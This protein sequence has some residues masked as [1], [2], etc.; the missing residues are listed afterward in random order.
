MKRF[1]TKA[2]NLFSVLLLAFALC[3]SLLCVAVPE[4]VTATWDGTAAASFASGS[5]TESSPYK[6]STEKQL[7]YFLQ[8][9]AAGVTYEGKY[10]QLTKSLDMTGGTWECAGTFQ[11][12]F[13]GM[14]YTITAECRFLN[15]VGEYGTVQGVNY[16]ATKTLDDDVFCSYNEGSLIG[17]VVMGDAKSDTSKTIWEES[18]GLLC[19]DNYGSVISCGGVGYVYAC[20]DDSSA[21]AGLIAKNHG[22]V[23]SCYSAVASSASAPGKYNYSHSHPLAGA[24]SGSVTNCIYNADIYT[25]TTNVGIGMTTEEMTGATILSLL[26]DNA[27]TNCRWALNDDFDGY[28]HMAPASPYKSYVSGYQ[29]KDLIVYNANYG[30]TSVTLSKNSS[31]GTIYY[32]LD[33]EETDPA[34]FTKYT[35]GSISIEGYQVLSSSVY[36]NGKFGAVTRQ[37]LFH[38]PGSGTVASPYQISTPRQLTALN[39][40]PEA[41]FVL[42]DDITFTEED[43]STTGASPDQWIPVDSFSGTLDGQ[44]YF[45]SGL[46]SRLGGLVDSNSGT[47]MNLR[48]IGHRLHSPYASGAI[49]NWNN[50]TITRCYTRS[51]FTLD[52]LP[53]VQDPAIGQY[54]GGVVGCNN[55][56]TV[57][58]CRN[59]GIVAATT[60]TRDAHLWL[61]GIVGSGDASNCINTGTV[62]LANTATISF[63]YLGGISGSGTATNCLYNGSFY[64]DKKCNYGTYI[65]GISGSHSNGYARYCIASDLSMTIVGYDDNLVTNTF[66]GIHINPYY[67]YKLNTVQLPTDAPALDF[68]NTWMISNDGPVPQGVMDAEGHAYRLSTTQIYPTCRAKGDQWVVCDICG[69][70]DVITVQAIGH[71]YTNY[72]SNGDATCLEDGTETAKC[73]R[74]DEG[75][76][77]TRTDTGSKLGHSFTNY[78]SNGDAACLKDGTKTAECD[79]CD[80]DYT[81]TKTDTGS[82]LGHSFTNYTSNNNATCLAD[83]SETA[84]CDRCDQTNTREEVGST[85]GHTYENYT[86]NN[87]AT[88][89]ADGTETG[90]CIRCTATDT[91]ADS[92]SALGHSFANYV[93]NGDAT[94]DTDGTKTAKCSRCSVTD[95]VTDVGS[96]GHVFTTYIS[97]GN[98]TCLYPGTEDAFCDLCGVEK[99]TRVEADSALGHSF[100]IYRGNGDATCLADGTETAR[101]DRCTVT[102]T[103][104]AMDSALGHSFTNY[105]SNGDVTCVADGTQTAKCDRCDATDTTSLEKL[106]H[107]L[108][109]WMTVTPPTC[110]GEGTER[111]DCSRCDHFET[112]AIPATGHSYET[113]VTAPTCTE[114]GYTTY[115]CHCGHSYQDDFV[116]A[117]DHTFETY[118]SDGNA[119]CTKAG[120]QTATCIRC[121]VTDTIPMKALGHSFTNYSAIGNATCTADGT[122]IATCDRCDKQDIAVDTGSKLNHTLGDWVAII[123]AGCLTEGE[124]KATCIRC[125]YFET[126]TLPAI[127]HVAVI[128]PAVAPTCTAT[129]LTE[130][131]HCSGCD[132]VYIP[133]TV[134]PIIAHTE[135]IDA[136]VAPTCTA[137]GLTEGKHCS[138]CSTVLVEQE[139]VDALGHTEAIDTAVAPTCTTAGLTEGKHCSVCNEVLVEQET[140]EALG[141]IAAA[142]VYENRVDPTCSAEGSVDEVILCSVCSYEMSR[143]TKHLDKYPHQMIQLTCDNSVQYQCALCNALFADADGRMSIEAL[144]LP[145]DAQ[146]I[147]VMLPEELRS[148]TLIL[149][150]YD[151]NEKMYG[152]DLEK[153]V[154]QTTLSIPGKSYHTIQL[155]IIDTSLQPVV[156]PVLFTLSR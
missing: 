102:D 28:P 113:K 31:Y 2:L 119:T 138:V 144:I 87:D 109:Q 126:K 79:R 25:Y 153:A 23:E 73:D 132:L 83:G 137:P 94:C 93:P 111:A 82:K 43:Y 130:G 48:M 6:I 38:L 62:V 128:D 96:A 11:G 100:T 45:I 22:T 92:G 105:I 149:A 72:V 146:S 61:G 63:P 86:G 107:A 12:N 134:L 67:C 8:Q 151:V 24:N 74:C 68:T 16:I 121:E 7:G 88:C 58:Y 42:A 140:V 114:K 76:T 135:A 123:P 142:P 148:A 69:E 52:S 49:A 57:S 112:Q 118:V 41:N 9:L 116:D 84:K 44:G 3:F 141:H 89:L 27:M 97:N 90:K 33:P 152:I 78:V 54:V 18:I 133:Q 70:T 46:Q 85:L 20:G 75:Y 115:T 127:G 77:D 71:R 14:G 81:D 26:S 120:T 80:D 154:L 53:S 10:I 129:G 91:R 55:G 37:K 29:G 32:S 30:S 50:G 5:G 122:K 98:A 47:I 147:T 59:D 125:K 110:L 51:A 4:Q 56:G 156:A 60:T 39:L 95:T 66:C 1:L 150:T 21:W 15:K 117:L 64:L 106:G 99:H 136:S 40:F 13:H 34:K 65:S 155:F 17:C 19:G 131:K 36:Y 139:T 103:R 124:A 35:S 145:A 104:A 101:C 143:T 108:G